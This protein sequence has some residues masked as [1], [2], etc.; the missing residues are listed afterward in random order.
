VL[1]D[2]TRQRHGQVEAQRQFGHAFVDL[3]GGVQ[4]SGGLH[5]IDLPLGLA[6][7][8]GQ[9]HVG[10]FD[11]R[12]FD[13]QEAETLV[14]S[15]D[16]IKHALEGDLVERQQLKHAGHGAGRGKRHGILY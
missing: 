4:G 6:A 14:V 11:H 3:T 10:I 12:R 5:E 13:R 8:L 2:I 15:A 1:G 7:G 16:D 9:Q